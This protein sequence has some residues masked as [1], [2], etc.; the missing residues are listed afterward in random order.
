[1][2]HDDSFEL[3][4]ASIW[5]PSAITSAWLA[6][7]PP[8]PGCST[9]PTP[10]SRQEWELV[11]R[12]RSLLEALELVE[13]WE[14]Q[15]LDK[16]ER[17]WEERGERFSCISARRR[18]LANVVLPAE[19]LEPIVKRLNLAPSA[20]LGELAEIHALLPLALPP[21]GALA[22][23]TIPSLFAAVQDL[24]ERTKALALES[25][26]AQNLQLSLEEEAEQRKSYPTS[27]ADALLWPFL[28]LR[29]DRPLRADFIPRPRLNKT[30]WRSSYSS[31][32]PCWIG[33][34]TSIALDSCGHFLSRSS[35]S[36]AN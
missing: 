23:D 4:S 28:L 36:Y 15:K 5:T 14:K 11:E 25:L 20:A 30:R 19:A 9:P 22:H 3:P 21:R 32:L 31:R 18:S 7:L 16:E 26:E 33:K 6:S 12:Y 35:P 13:G 24:D 8:P 1:M 34:R 2:L 29:T 27:Y 17:E 10:A